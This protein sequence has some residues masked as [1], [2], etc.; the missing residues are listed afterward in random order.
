MAASGGGKDILV[1][2]PPRISR[3]E[4]LSDFPLHW[5]VWHKDAASLEEELALN[6]VGWEDV[7]FLSGSLRFI[8]ISFSPVCKYWDVWNLCLVLLQHNKEAL[9]RRGRTPLHL[10]VT[11]GYVDCV[12]CLLNGGCDAN[13]INNDGWNG[14]YLVRLIYLNK[15]YFHRFH[16]L[17]TQRDGYFTAT[18]ENTYSLKGKRYTALCS[19]L[20][21]AVLISF[22]LCFD[23]SMGRV[24]TSVSLARVLKFIILF[25]FHKSKRAFWLKSIDRQN[26][27][28]K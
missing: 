23:Q 1:A 3:D 17:D 21:E 15:W 13:A 11:L 27:E 24:L 18:R 8:I 14:R 12:K 9:D 10:A 6:R 5:H 19:C 20:L 4:I 22:I 25:L 26:E 28:C 7:S 2:S 16:K